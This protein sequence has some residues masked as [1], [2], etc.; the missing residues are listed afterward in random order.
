MRVVSNSLASSDKIFFLSRHINLEKILYDE[1]IPYTPL[2]VSYNGCVLFEGRKKIMAHHIT[3]SWNAVPG[4]SGYNVYRGTQLGNESHI[5]Y[6]TSLVTTSFFEDDAV[7][8]GKSYSYSVTSVING[9]ESS[10]SLD[11]LSPP[12]PF[13]PAPFD[14][15]LGLASSFIILAGSA[16]T[17]TGPTDASGDVGRWPGTSI[18]GFGFPASIAKHS[19]WRFRRRSWTRR[20]HNS[21]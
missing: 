14:V 11:I 20:H 10:G 2:L 12:V 17:N 16:I 3:I 5:P 13:P 18:T 7:F 4:V 9:V 1:Y 15:D 8:A 21:I 19:S 6:N